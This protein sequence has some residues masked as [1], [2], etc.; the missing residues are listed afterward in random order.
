METGNKFTWPLQKEA[1]IEFCKWACI[2]NYFSPATTS[3]YVASFK[4]I[5]KL[6]NWNTDVCENFLA[7]SMIRGAE[8]LRCPKQENK[9]RLTMTLPLLKILGHQIAIQTWSKYNKQ[10]YWTAS[11]IAFFGAFR[12]GEILANDVNN[13][14]PIT[15]LLWNDINLYKDCWII[16]IKSPKSRKAEG[17]F[18]NIFK[19][20]GQN[21]CPYTAIS[22]LK[23]MCPE[24]KK[25]NKPVFEFDNGKFLTIQT[26]NSTL[27]NLL[28]PVIGQKC[29]W[30][31]GHSFRAGIASV[32]DRNTELTKEWGRWKSQA[33]NAYARLHYESRKKCFEKICVYM[34]SSNNKSL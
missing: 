8:N 26:F 13:F 3:A 5:H 34:N 1:I 22:T 28:R 14:D 11:C 4:F 32:L 21:C 25:S 9:H 17:E 7:K 19:F 16:H 23:G 27:S 2:K 15:T 33:C 18:V 20:E 6:N 12:M 30:L 31:S 10:I 29:E 24:S